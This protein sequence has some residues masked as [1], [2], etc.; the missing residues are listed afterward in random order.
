MR[1]IQWAAVQAGG[2]R[3][4]L[5]ATARGVCRVALRRRREQ[6]LEEL[7]RMFPRSRLV[8]APADRI[9]VQAAGELREYF[10]GR[11]TRFTVPL[12]LRGTEF[13]LRVWN[14]LVEIP[15]GETRSYKEV[16]AAIGAPK[17]VRAVGAANGRNPAPIFVPC[18]RVV[19]ASGSL[20]GFSAGLDLKAKLLA[21]EG[22]GAGRGS[23]GR[24]RRCVSASSGR[25][26]R[27]P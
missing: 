14:A 17:A 26:Y 20:H 12:D 7:R 16:A 25:V 15:Y 9:L 8:R 5:A 18:H 10:A 23:G 4:Y 2:L 21:I 27:C 3:I 19:A 1:D 22:A 6:F 13:Q 11:R 24:R